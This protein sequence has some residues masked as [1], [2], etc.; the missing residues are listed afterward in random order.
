MNERGM[1]MRR[2][3]IMNGRRIGRMKGRRIGRMKG[4]RIGRM[5]MRR[6]DIVHKVYRHETLFTK[7]TGMRHCSQSIQA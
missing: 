6:I 4:R 5:K 7:Y 2:L 1:K 3:G